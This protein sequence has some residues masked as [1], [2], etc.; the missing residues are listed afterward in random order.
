MSEFDRLAEQLHRELEGLFLRWPD[1]DPRRPTATYYAA[2]A[3]NIKD[4]MDKFAVNVGRLMRPA[5][6]RM[7]HCLKELGEQYEEWQRNT[8]EAWL[9]RH[10]VPRFLSRNIATVLP[11]RWLP[12]LH[13]YF[14][15]E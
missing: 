10:R 12:P 5:F 11:R 2:A 13:W 15:G 6:E 4:A 3:Q 7:A 9:I 14:R 8:L 1:I